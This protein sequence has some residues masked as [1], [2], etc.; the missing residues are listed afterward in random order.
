MTIQERWNKG[1]VDEHKNMGVLKNKTKQNNNKKR[2]NKTKTDQRTQLR[3]IL[4][5]SKN[6]IMF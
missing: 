2:S 1:G 5:I 4:Y 3:S 6:Y